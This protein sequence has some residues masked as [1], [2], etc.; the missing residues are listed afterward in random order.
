VEENTVDS[1]SYLLSFW[2]QDDPLV[3]P[4]PRGGV[5]ETTLDEL[6]YRVDE[7]VSDTEQIWADQAAGAVIEFVLPRSLLTLPVH[8]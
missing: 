2:R 6:E 7:I 8:R 5:R 3:W 4:P 1:D